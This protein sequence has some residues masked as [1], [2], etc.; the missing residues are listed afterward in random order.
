MLDAVEGKGKE[1][2]NALR[3]KN[4]V[5]VPGS[6]PTAGEVAAPEIGLSGIEL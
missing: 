6:A 4:A 1:I 2:V 5:I 3:D